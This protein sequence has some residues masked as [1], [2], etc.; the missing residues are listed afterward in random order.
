MFILFNCSFNKEEK[1]I[2]KETLYSENVANA[3]LNY[4]FDLQQN[5][6]KDNEEE[7]ENNF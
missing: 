1:L 3:K 7:D 2:E 4:F 6:S 5:N